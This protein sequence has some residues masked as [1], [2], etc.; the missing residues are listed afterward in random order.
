MRRV[1]ANV[2]NVV[3]YMDDISVHSTSVSQHKQDL[4]KVF[5]ILKSAG[6]TLNQDKCRFFQ[7]SIDFL[8]FRVQGREIRPLPSKVKAI[9][10]FPRPE[11]EAALRRFL[12]LASYYRALIPD[13]DVVASPLFKLTAMGAS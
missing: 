7:K 10:E 12:G 8:G 11:D 13:F 5:G 6:L 3:C 2:P 4:D 9:A 1:F